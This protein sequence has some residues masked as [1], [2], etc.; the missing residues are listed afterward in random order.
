MSYL[1]SALPNHDMPSP[2]FLES[3]AIPFTTGNS[4][5]KISIDKSVSI[6]LFECIIVFILQYDSADALLF[7]AGQAPSMQIP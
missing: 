6:S 7:I 4:Q 3:A 1:Q 2:W 5:G